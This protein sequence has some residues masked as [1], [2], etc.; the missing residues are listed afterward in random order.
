VN[1]VLDLGS[2]S[3]ANLISILST[4]LENI[5]AIILSHLHSDHISDISVLRY[6]VFRSNNAVD[7]NGFAFRI[8]LYCPAEPALEYEMLL[9]YTQFDVQPISGDL[10]LEFGGMKLN[11]AAMKHPY[12][13]FAV[14]A[15]ADGCASAAD[16]GARARRIFVY[17]G[18]TSWSQEL[19]QFSE[20]ADL[21]LADANLITQDRLAGKPVYHLTAEECGI[22]AAE[23][24]AAKLL[25]TH[26]TPGADVG[27]RVAEARAGAQK[28][29]GRSDGLLVEDASI[30]TSYEI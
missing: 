21:L 24:G 11:F 22:A 10:E 13:S 12:P 25:L 1:V 3:L 20:G 27:R 17:S 8:P 5:D 4:D 18:D 2:G 7:K 16:G 9:A 6:A 14:R 28:V 29:L 26:F 15:A 19:I 30:L 23:A